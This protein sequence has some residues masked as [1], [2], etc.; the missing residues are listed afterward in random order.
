VSLFY[1]PPFSDWWTAAG[2]Y[3]LA[4]ELSLYL[5]VVLVG[6]ALVG[7]VRERAARPWLWVALIF[8]VLALG[9]TLRVWGRDTGVPLPYA[10][11]AKLPVFRLAGVPARLSFMAVLCLALAAGY[12]VAALAR[13]RWRGSEWLL[14]GLV[15]VEYCCAP[16]LTTPDPATGFYH[17]LAA[18]PGDFAVLDVPDLARAMHCQTLHG[19]RLLLGR[20]S[21]PP[22]ASTRLCE[23]DKALR[24]LWVTWAKCPEGPDV[25]P[26]VR[27]VLRGVNCRYLIA[28]G[29][30]R[31]A[32]IEGTL[33]LTKAPNCA[34]TRRRRRQHHRRGA[35]GSAASPASPNSSISSI[36]S[37]RASSSK[38]RRLPVRVYSTAAPIK[39]QAGAS[40]S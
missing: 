12:G 17:R 9:P 22:H 24:A 35:D 26:R 11:L 32:W 40:S 27:A 38:G 34:S 10:L 14:A 20:H 13:G 39:R 21:Y 23:E 15:C 4:P 2:L 29:D 25:G 3:S 19:K 36:R 31:R 28:H 18:E 7:G 1:L 8:L 5:G 33:G 6:L 16:V 30:F 37:S